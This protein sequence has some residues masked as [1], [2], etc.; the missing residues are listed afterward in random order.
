MFKYK[1]QFF[2]VVVV[3]RN[4]ITRQPKLANNLGPD[5]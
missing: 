4:V 3:A 2:V 1:I 5:N